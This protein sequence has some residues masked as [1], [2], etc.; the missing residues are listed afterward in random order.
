MPFSPNVLLAGVVDLDATFLIQWGIF[1]LFFFI[2]RGWVWKPFMDIL[3]R[4]D[5]EINGLRVEAE[6]SEREAKVREHTYQEK[7]REAQNSAVARRQSL[8]DQ[9][10]KAS[11]R[12]VEDARITA[13]KANTE[14]KANL[15]QQAQESRVKMR[16]EAAETAK[17]ICEQILGR[18]VTS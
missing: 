6:K 16:A 14:I 17:A 1:L 4:R 18:K 7:Y 15:E 10:Q 12:V 3:E 8:L 11:V 2:V 9:E 5:H 13:A